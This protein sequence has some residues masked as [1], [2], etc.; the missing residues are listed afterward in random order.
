MNQLFIGVDPGQS[1][2]ICLLSPDSKEIV[3]FLD[4]NMHPPVLL[5]ILN[6]LKD[7]YLLSPV[8]L[9]K[10]QNIRGTASAAN[11]KFGF[12][13]GNISGIIK[14]SNIGLDQVAPKVWQKMLQVPAK[15][16]KTARKKFIGQQC[17]ALYPSAELHGPRG[18]LLDGRSDALGIAHYSR[19]KYGNKV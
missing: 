15:L 18:G 4:I 11:F 10:V 13:Y 19:I 12:N 16:E 1:G 6:G 5:G 14:C 3:Q 7:E 8:M 2:S 17:M 9:E